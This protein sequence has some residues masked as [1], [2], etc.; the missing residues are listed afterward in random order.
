MKKILSFILSIAFI[1]SSGLT[2]A[3]SE[4]P[5][6]N[7]SD[8]IGDFFADYSLVAPP[9]PVYLPIIMYH[10]IS[11]KQSRLGTYI[12]SP[13][14][15]ENDLKLFRD[16]GFTT[17][18]VND[19]IK[20]VTQKGGLPDKPIMLTFDD[21]NESDYIYALPLLQKYQMKAIFSVVG[22]FTDDYSRPDVIKNIDYAMMSW[23]DIKAMYDSGLA[24]FQNHSYDLH[25]NGSRNGALPRRFEDTGEYQSL[26]AKDLG[27]LNA[28]F[29]EH[30]GHEPEAF[31][32]P[33]G[34][35]N[36]RL[37]EAVRKAGFSVILTS[38]QKM[39][40]LTGDPEELFFL[41]RYLRTH[42]KDVKGLV[43]SWDEYYKAYFRPME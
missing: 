20:F 28:A 9:D 24:D 27:K 6:F 17:V 12:I 41:K 33:F 25:K 13:D 40:V 21:G 7:K 34:A 19:L 22:K 35:F 37:K 36:D 11:A 8:D 15:F 10:Q 3:G 1:V 31:T 26:I 38:Y 5:V 2:A 4:W 43:S 39:N 42:N 32:V 30:I 23:D 16:Q 18:T 14:E 29:K